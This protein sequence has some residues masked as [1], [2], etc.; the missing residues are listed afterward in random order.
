[1]TFTTPFLNF[2]KKLCP[3]IQ[4]VFDVPKKTDYRPLH[5]FTSIITIA[6]NKDLICWTSGR[7][8]SPVHMRDEQAGQIKQVGGDCEK[9]KIRRLRV[10]KKI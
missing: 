7:N 2:Y 5:F 9:Q 1:M 3:Q 6:G 8:V 10:L 4:H